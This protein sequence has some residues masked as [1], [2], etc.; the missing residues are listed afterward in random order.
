MEKGACLPTE[1]EKKWSV[2]NFLHFVDRQ[3]YSQG[4]GLG[5]MKLS[6]YPSEGLAW[7]KLEACKYPSDIFHLL[8]EVSVSEKLALQKFLFT[9][10]AIGGTLRGKF[11][12]EEARKLLPQSIL[13][14]PLEFATQTKQFQFFHWLVKVARKM[15]DKAR[16]KM[17]KHFSRHPKV[18]SNPRHFE[19]IPEL[20]V[21]L[22]HTKIIT[23][24]CSK[25]LEE[26]LE[27][28]KSHYGR[29]AEERTRLDKCV[30]YLAPFNSEQPQNPRPLSTGTHTLLYSQL[31]RN[32]ELSSY[33]N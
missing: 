28:C 13:P 7:S 21:V 6:L 14:S 18:Q 17:I 33:N 20:F 19:T 16:G 31:Q 15:P 2:P 11:C 9:L 10:E 30:G 23:E 22:Y 1:E 5:L 3:I 25:A 26:E 12:A 4:A 24:N 8:E 29:D 32:T 27:K